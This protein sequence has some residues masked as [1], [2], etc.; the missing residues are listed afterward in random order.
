MYMIPFYIFAWIASI[1]YGLEVIVIKLANKH[2]SA[3]L[4]VFNF[5]WN[6]LVLLLIVPFAVANHAVIPGQWF[7]VVIAA[8][9]YA[10]AG[11]TYVINLSKLDVS[12][13]APLFNFRTV[14]AVILAAVFLHER[15][16]SEQLLLISVIFLGGFFVSIDEEFYFKSFFNKK[17]LYTLLMMVFIALEAVYINKSIDELGFWTASLWIAI[18]AQGMLLVTWPKFGKDFKKIG[19]K[20]FGATLLGALTGV[21]GILASNKLLHL[22]S[23]FLQQSSLCQFP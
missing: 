3:N 16:S 12:V 4:W 8:L 15:L 10:I 5:L 19:P 11:I 7:N 13:F 20:E 18:I 9:L 6:F 14:F 1:A 23:E 2:L 17:I 21:V 22:T